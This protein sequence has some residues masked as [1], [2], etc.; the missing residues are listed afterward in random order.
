MEMK[1]ILQGQHVLELTYNL[2]DNYMR[3]VREIVRE[4]EKS[5]FTDDTM[6]MLWEIAPELEAPLRILNFYRE[7]NNDLIATVEK[8]L[9]LFTILG[10][11]V[12]PR[13]TL[14][15]GMVFAMEPHLMQTLVV[16]ILTRED[17]IFGKDIPNVKLTNNRRVN[18]KYEIESAFEIL[19]NI[20]TDSEYNV[21]FESLTLFSDRDFVR[22]FLDT[23]IN[24]Y[25]R[26][27][28]GLYFLQPEIYNGFIEWGMSSLNKQIEA[29]P[30]D[31]FSKSPRFGLFFDEND[32]LGIT[33]D[34]YLSLVAFHNTA[35]RRLK[36]PDYFIHYYME[37]RDEVR[38]HYH[39][40]YPF[41]KTVK[42]TEATLTEHMQDDHTFLLFESEKEEEKKD[43]S[44]S[45]H[46]VKKFLK[47]SREITRK[48]LNSL[49]LKLRAPIDK[50]LNYGECIEIAEFW[51][52]IPTPGIAEIFE[53]VKLN[54]SHLINLEEF[55]LTG[56]AMDLFF[57]VDDSKLLKIDTHILMK[58]LIKNM[59]NYNLFDIEIMKDLNINE[60]LKFIYTRIYFYTRNM[61]EILDIG[62][63]SSTSIEILK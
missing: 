1:E 43:R 62:D 37:T 50:K 29:R 52:L 25:K 58:L 33:L 19:K 47:G 24:S 38:N 20:A 31:L 42:I 5:P 11:P 13:I 51:G 57:K 4:N 28:L 54:A 60:N 12:D 63:E 17:E 44:K 61:L 15:T 23:K 34:F 49:N 56:K 27:P 16:F 45:Y 53:T 22:G 48:Q 39:D 9:G 7:A 6:E 14:A 26:S 55:N 35:K 21:K 32:L 40:Y 36:N 46:E 8:F 3:T 18:T 2:R 30:T 10:T 59:R 41:S